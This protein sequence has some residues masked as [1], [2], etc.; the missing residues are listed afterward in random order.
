[1][2]IRRINV[3]ATR[4]V[5]LFL[6][7]GIL[8]LSGCSAINKKRTLIINGLVIQNRTAETIHDIHIQVDETKA[9]AHC[10][11]VYAD[12]ECT[13]TFREKRYQG[14]PIRV[15]WIQNGKTWQTEQFFAKIPE[16]IIP[17]QTASLYVVV[18]GNGAA[19][20]SLVQ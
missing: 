12:G 5:L 3:T 13:T 7:I 11:H 6:C 10:S 18:T 19:T 17:E 9:F 4:D 2:L 15:I 8:L 1:M 14:T 16:P 20:A